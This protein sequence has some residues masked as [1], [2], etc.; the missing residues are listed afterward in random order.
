MI[1]RFKLEGT[2][3]FIVIAFMLYYFL[4][5]AAS[6]FI[7]P[8][9]V[10]GLILIY[11]MYIVLIS[12][13]HRVQIFIIGYTALISFIAL[14]YILLTESAGDLTVIERYISKFSQWIEMFFPILLLHRFTKL[15]SY[16]TKVLLLIF[17]ILI[18]VLVVG[19]SFEVLLDNPYAA[20]QW[21]GFDDIKLENA[22]TYEYVYALCAL[23]P[24][25]Y[26]CMVTVKPVY[27]KV[28]FII[29]IVILFN[30]LI[31]AQ[32]TI[33]IVL[34][35][36][37]CLIC[38]YRKHRN[39]VFLTISIVV[40]VLFVLFLPTILM[41]ISTIFESETISIRFKETALFLAGGE[42]SNKGDLT[43]RLNIYRQCLEYFIKSPIWGNVTVPFNT[44]ST[45]LGVM[46]DLGIIGIIPIFYL[47]FTIHRRIYEILGDCDIKNYFI[48]ARI[49]W[50][51][52]GLLNPIHAALPLNM[53]VWFLVPAIAYVLTQNTSSTINKNTM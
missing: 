29:I 26:M 23:V 39:P 17:A 43:S 19:N 27:I 30:L 35:V 31:V 7:S 51:L 13:S 9:F 44:H 53:V 8:W 2:L 41:C 36:V 20:R 25:V 1:I 28:I 49:T 11:S 47:S 37:S 34:A 22:V 21:S 18:L 48:P 15:K 38:F 5:P 10:L 6:V 33:S 40:G 50:I 12:K 32:Y 45:F 42:V 52:L 46:C 3:D 24:M 4:L 16:K 14:L